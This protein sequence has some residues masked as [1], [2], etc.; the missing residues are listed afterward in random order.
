ML[1]WWDKLKR[2]FYS[3]ALNEKTIGAD[4]R[5]TVINLADTKTIGILYD[6]TNPDND[7]IITKF[8]E[9]LRNSGKQVEILAYQHDTKTEHKAD[10]QVFNKKG[11]SWCGVPFDKRALQFAGKKYDLLLACF[12]AENLPLEFISAMSKARWRVGA[13][14]KA[15]TNC[16]DMMINTGDKANVQ[17]FITQATEFLKNIKYDT[18]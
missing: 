10:V 6:S 17:Y 18:N 15:K 12:T 4:T 1:Q 3:R 9:Q 16:F 5:R 13:Y 7:I 11:V 2:Y 14:N 8:A